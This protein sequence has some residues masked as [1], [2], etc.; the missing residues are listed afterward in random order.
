MI[1]R[2]RPYLQLR[3]MIASDAIRPDPQNVV[4]LAANLAARLTVRPATSSGSARAHATAIAWR[5]RYRTLPS[6]TLPKRTSSR[7]SVFSGNPVSC[8]RTA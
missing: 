7:G 6:T 5:S 3:A 4:Q 8:S 1:G 2:F